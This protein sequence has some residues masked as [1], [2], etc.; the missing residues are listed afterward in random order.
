MRKNLGAVSLLYPQIVV[1]ASYD[2]N[3]LPNALTAGIG[4][5]GLDEITLLLDKHHM[6]IIRELC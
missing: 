5:S 1:V 6:E 4:I 2:K 3:G